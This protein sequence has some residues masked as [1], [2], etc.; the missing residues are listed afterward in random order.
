M[1]IATHSSRREGEHRQQ[2]CMIIILMII[3]I[4][5]KFKAG[6]IGKLTQPD[7]ALRHGAKVDG[8]AIHFHPGRGRNRRK[9]RCMIMISTMIL[10]TIAVK[11][12]ASLIDKLAW[13]GRCL[14]PRRK[15]MWNC[16]VFAFSVRENRQQRCM[17]S[18][19]M[20]ITIAMK[21]KAGFIDELSRPDL[22][23]RHGAKVDGIAIH[24]LPGRGRNGKERCMIMISTSILITITVKFKAS[25]IDKLAWAGLALRHGAKVYGTCIIFAFNVGENP[26]S[27]PR[28][29]HL[30]GHHHCDEVQGQLHQQ[31]VM[32]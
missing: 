5:M 4:A 32:A 7:L 27:A 24:F 31:T 30:D 14:A 15:S 13:A 6:F 29:P 20:I 22:A 21:F 23:L 9:E 3:T 25:L 8:I 10:I 2:R 28:G 19:L 26:P 12:K 16:N 17:I 11:F 1:G 18:I